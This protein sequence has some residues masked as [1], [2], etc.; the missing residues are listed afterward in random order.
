MSNSISL[1]RKTMSD[2]FKKDKD[3]E[4]AY[5]ANIAMLLFD[6]Y[7]KAQFRNVEKRESAAKDILNLIFNKK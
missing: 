3:F 2:A 6:R 4:Y 7:N 5:I 1:A